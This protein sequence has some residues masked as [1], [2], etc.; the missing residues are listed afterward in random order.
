MCQLFETIKI[1]GGK[2]ENLE[3]H[4]QRVKRS[5]MAVFGQPLAGGISGLIQCPA[6]LS[7]GIVKCRVTYSHRILSVT[8]EPY[9]PRL[10]RSLQLVWDDSIE[11]SHK[12]ADRSHL[13]HLK[14]GITADEI[15]I[16]KNGL[17]TDTSFSNIIFSDGSSW[18]TP[19]RPLLEG[20][21]RAQL[22][23]A[24]LLKTM[25]IRPDDLSRFREARLI[26]AMLAPDE[27][28]SIHIPAGIRQ[29]NI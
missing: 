18:F 11:Y 21:K 16:V 27:S 25:D 17:L 7:Q 4:E 3:F 14:S 19:A 24:G 26:N 8:Y 6:G 13:E 2:A 5:S 29:N 23:E 12:F 22:L 15:L 1:T 10:V 28:P 20:T 9:T